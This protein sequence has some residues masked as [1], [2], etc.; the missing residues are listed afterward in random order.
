MQMGYFFAHF[1]ESLHY[2]VH[3]E[4]LVGFVAKKCALLHSL[5]APCREQLRNAL[6]RSPPDYRWSMSG[7]LMREPNQPTFLAKITSATREQT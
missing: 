1:A 5:E 7:L 4:L 2:V 6:Q 3:Y